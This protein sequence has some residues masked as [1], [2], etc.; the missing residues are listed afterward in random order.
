[1]E[2]RVL[3]KRTGAAVANAEVTIVGLTGSA[4]TDADG[5]F[6]WKPD[7]KP[8]FVILVMLSDGRVARPISVDKLEAV[9]VLTVTIEAAVT[10][11]VTV[12]AGVA[13]SIEAAP[14]SALTMVS[15]RDLFM[16]SPANLMQALENVPGVSQV[17]EGQAAVP[18]VRGLARGRTLILV[19]GSRVSS[20][21]RVG[22]S[23]TF[24]DPTVAEGVDVARGPG[25]VAY[26]LDAIGG[27][28]SVRTRRPGFT[29]TR[30]ESSATIGAGIPDRRVDVSFARGFGGVGGILVAAHTRNV[31]DHDSPQGVVL[32]SGYADHGA[33]VRA[34]RAWANGV[35]SASWQGDFGRDIERPRNNSNAVRFYYP[36]DDSHRFNV[37][38]ERPT[39][40]GFS[41]LKT[42]GF[43]G[44]N[45]Q[46]TDQD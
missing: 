4:R 46:R 12:A 19:D 21:R 11:E 17:S 15:S 27:V 32:N 41:L 36:F 43:L 22:P 18:A 29:G 35:L 45:T 3:D 40:A 16:R 34:E 44:T 28:I 39:T 20:E 5:R 10:D 31:E 13:P 8:P 6:T 25:S 38:Y 7:P 26:G 1:M 9:G 2:G 30:F 33:L 37:S 24:M 14:G 42:S 23:A